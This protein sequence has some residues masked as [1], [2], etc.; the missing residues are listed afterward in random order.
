MN[1]FQKMQTLFFDE[2]KAVI[3]NENII[4]YE[5]EPMNVDTASQRLQT[6]NILDSVYVQS[7]ILERQLFSAEIQA[8]VG[9]NCGKL[10]SAFNS[11]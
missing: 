10:L 3:V 5:N 9:N 8:A 6:S 4:S 1:R 11:F 2:Q 7:V